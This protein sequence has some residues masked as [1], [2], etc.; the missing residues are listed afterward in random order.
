MKIT[1]T[2]SNI[3]VESIQDLKVGTM[4]HF[5]N[6]TLEEA[7]SSGELFIKIR[8][9]SNVQIP[10]PEHTSVLSQSTYVRLYD[11]FEFV[12]RTGPVMGISVPDWSYTFSNSKGSKPLEQMS[13]G[14]FV[15]SGG[16]VDN[17]VNTSEG[18]YLIITDTVESNKMV[19]LLSLTDHSIIKV[20]PQAEFL[21]LDINININ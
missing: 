21:E 16:Y 15:S 20:S 3:T 19:S 5:K 2:Q 6:T 12:Q 17:S 14:T 8:N 1:K 9:K 18:V 7:M 11:K 4:F 10:V 13:E